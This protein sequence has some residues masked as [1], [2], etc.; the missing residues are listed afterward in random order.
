M[1]TR[2]LFGL[3]LTTLGLALLATS[4]SAAVLHFNPR[5]GS[6][7]VA[8]IS[9]LFLALGVIVLL[10]DILEVWLSRGQAAL[11]DGLQAG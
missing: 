1:R 4:V 9:I 5:M 8:A 10:M 6:G 7:V 11:V 3:F 2:R